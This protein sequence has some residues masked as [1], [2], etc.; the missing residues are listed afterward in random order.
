MEGFWR[1]IRH[2][3]RGLTK[4]RGFTIAALLSLAAAIGLNT[5]VFS[6]T[7][8]VLLRPF[9]YYDA[10][11]LVLV[12]GTK[13]IDV[14]R[15]MSGEN[16]ENW[17]KQSQT[18][19][20]IAVFQMNPFPFSVGNDSTQNVQGALV[21]TNAF[22]VLGVQPLLG[23][24]F[25]ELENQPGDDKRVIL[26]Y[27]FWQ[28]HFAG[29]TGVVGKTIQL[30]GEI[31][32]V[33]GVMPEG[34]FFPDED[35]QL[36]V[37][38]TRASPVFEQVHA[39]ARLRRGVTIRQ[40]QAELD[41]LSKRTAQGPNI[42]N[43]TESGVF[44]LYRIVIGKFQQALWVLLG[45]VSL[46]LLL[47]CANVSNMWL[48]RTVEREKEFAVRVTFGASRT[49]VLRLSLAENI[50][51]SVV[52]GVLGV[53]CASLLLVFLRNLNLTQIPH[54]QSAHIDSHVLLFALGL[55][56]L[57]AI[58]SGMVP[59]WKSAHPNLY[60]SLQLG[61]V[62]THPPSHGQAR[63]FVVAIEVALAVVLL[64]GAGLL[65][66]SFVR[67]T[68]ADWGF[69]P[70]HL[71][72]VEEQFPA[73][74]H[75]ARCD[76]IVGDISQ[77]LSKVPF[78]RSSAVAYGIPIRY[79][80][81]RTHLSLDGRIVTSD[82][83]AGTWTIGPGYFKTMGIPILRGR[84]FGERDIQSGGRAVV[85]SKDLAERLWP[86]Q[87]PIGKQL[88]IMRLTKAI[89]DQ[90]RRNH[91]AILDKETWRSAK[92]WEADGSPS[93]VIGEVGNVRAFG[94]D[95]DSADS[96]ALYIDYGHASSPA[97]IY[98]LI[99]R[100]SVDPL[101]VVSSVKQQIMAAAPESN[102]TD[103]EIMSNLVSRSIGGRGSNKLLLVISVLFGTL[104]LLLAT[105]GI[106]GVVSFTTAQRTREI[107]IRRSLGGQRGDIFRMVLFQGMRPVLEGLALGIVGAFALTRLLTGILFGVTPTD[108]TTFVG[109]S[110][111]LIVAALA[112]CIVPALRALRISPVETLRYE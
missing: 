66:G 33:L 67:L 68:H 41:T 12:W 88:Q 111:L 85:V 30:N 53:L 5:A 14:R 45:A 65:V 54:F 37:P 47:G 62:S 23:R 36:W 61:G 48:A 63:N 91:T 97:H 102:I 78:V 8:A 80:W 16:V 13:S 7:D 9:P 24:V 25:S 77:R 69:N 32:D 90:M 75:K 95:F 81:H 22:S 59:A 17:R 86:G 35:I 3:A 49:R 100:T 107:G 103:T 96:P 31:Y 106:Y 20:D 94:L 87:N 42:P 71:L 109:I 44:S 51:L 28:S 93:E 26:S 98:R 43:G 40:A 105:V 18:L 11:R 34:F 15:G 55:S 92:S 83:E 38:L 76:E 2:G 21:G 29:N 58:F 64:V 1:D 4:T 82:W 70:D 108:P 57:A 19:A 56:L 73:D 112:A 60:A 6:F 110:I 84:E 104:S 27:G 52:A 79:S 50:I 101:K 99:A 39:L 72:I 74:T 46:L 89:E 10:G